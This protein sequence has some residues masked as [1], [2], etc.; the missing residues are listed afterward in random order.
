MLASLS[1]SAATTS[2]PSAANSLAFA[3]LTSLVSARTAYWPCLSLRI[4][5]TSPPPCAP[6]APTTAMILSGIAHPQ[7]LTTSIGRDGPERPI[8]A[9]LSP[10]TS[11]R[12]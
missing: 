10:H 8:Q 4:A 5:L 6:V 11:Q 3:E 12:L 2:A 1:T 7:R 9:V